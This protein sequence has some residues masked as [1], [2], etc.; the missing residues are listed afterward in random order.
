VAVCISLVVEVM[1]QGWEATYQRST[2][3]N[4]TTIHVYGF[5]FAWPRLLPLPII[6][7]DSLAFCSV[8]HLHLVTLVHS[9]AVLL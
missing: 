7:G 1:F 8:D 6:P 9:F 3:K 4:K 2:S 5:A